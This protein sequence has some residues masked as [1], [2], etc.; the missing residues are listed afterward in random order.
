MRAYEP[1]WER[2]KDKQKLIIKVDTPSETLTL[3]ELQEHARKIRRAL[4][5]EKQQDKEFLASNP[6]TKLEVDN[7]DAK[8]GTITFKLYNFN[9]GADL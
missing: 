7:L 1:M 6:S 2:L 5:K 9:I 4:S 8:S 3:R